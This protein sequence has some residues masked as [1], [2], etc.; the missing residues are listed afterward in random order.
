M[1]RRA[2]RTRIT[3][4]ARTGQG[5]TQ[6][7]LWGDDAPV[8]TARSTTGA[9]A[10]TLP[11]NDPEQW[12]RV[13]SAAA[14]DAGLMVTVGRRGSRRVM[15]RVPGSDVNGDAAHVT[16]LPAADAAVVLQALDS[17][18]VALGAG[19]HTVRHGRY[20]GPAVRVPVPA[21]TRHLLARWAALRPLGKD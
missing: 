16:A 3:P 10:A 17:G 2:T 5:P 19:R 4:S 21:R 20:E 11:T 15:A 7:G 13:L 6:A 1:T 12:A 9:A 14:S 18:H 8:P